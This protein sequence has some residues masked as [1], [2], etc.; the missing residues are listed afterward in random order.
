MKATKTVAMSKADIAGR[1]RHARGFMAAAALVQEFEDEVG[2]G[3]TENVVA[4][5]AV[6]AGIAASDAICGQA[7]GKRSSGEAHQEAVA[8]LKTATTNGPT[9]AKDLNRLLSLKANAQ[10]SSNMLTR[11]SSDEAVKWSERLVKGMEAELLGPS[12]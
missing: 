11:S 2:A 6:L 5:L 8:L 12:R 9:Y 7:L 4:S 10:Y 3:T 1:A